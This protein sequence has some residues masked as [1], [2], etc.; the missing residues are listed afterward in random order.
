MSAQDP[1]A[2]V[3]P[4][5]APNQE[6]T[7]LQEESPETFEIELHMPVIVTLNAVE[8][9]RPITFDPPPLQ[10]ITLDADRPKPRA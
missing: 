4:F 3:A 1:G 6:A 9:E 8:T 10:S 5:A 2:Q 7:L